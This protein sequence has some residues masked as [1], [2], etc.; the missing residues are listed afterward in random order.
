MKS[1]IVKGDCR[2]IYYVAFLQSDKFLT[3]IQTI[4]QP[5]EAYH[6]SHDYMNM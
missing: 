4:V 3:R 2:S 1:L 5:S 6:N